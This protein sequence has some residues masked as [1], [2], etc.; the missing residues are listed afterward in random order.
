MDHT[1]G[2]RKGPGLASNQ[3]DRFNFDLTASPM[4]P[5]SQSS[6]FQPGT[7]IP[8][9]LPYHL[10]P[11]ISMVAPPRVNYNYQYPQ[12][13]IANYSP[14][15]IPRPQM[16]SSIIPSGGSA[17]TPGNHITEQPVIDLTHPDIPTYTRPRQTDGRKFPHYHASG[18]A[19][20]KF[21]SIANGPRPNSII[22]APEKTE[23]KQPEPE[24]AKVEER[25]AERL[26]SKQPETKQEEIQQTEGQ[27]TQNNQQGVQQHEE[28]VPNL[29]YNLGYIWL[30]NRRMSAEKK[31][32]EAKKIEEEGERMAPSQPLVLSPELLPEEPTIDPKE[33]MINTTQTTQSIHATRHNQLADS[34]EPPQTTQTSQVP[35]VAQTTQPTHTTQTV[36]IIQSPLPLTQAARY[37]HHLPHNHTAVHVGTTQRNRKVCDV[38]AIRRQRQHIE[39]R[40]APCGSTLDEIHAGPHVRF[41]KIELNPYFSDMPKEQ[42]SLWVNHLPE[43]VPGRNDEVMRWS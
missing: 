7:G 8:T 17:F 13:F 20:T 25:E 39:F 30:E 24:Q 40:A 9:Y 21:G 26:E 42:I 16:P 27:Q 2:C 29:P 28:V 36:S 34:G 35:E 43:I 23:A 6:H 5:T 10:N 12:P 1:T 14:Y 15:H 18:G 31:E 3:G 19:I 4:A 33:L 22:Q 37:T 38:Y 11:N 41:D 32:R